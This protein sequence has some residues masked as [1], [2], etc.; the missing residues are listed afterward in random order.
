MP[1]TLPNTTLNLSTVDQLKAVYEYVVAELSLVDPPNPFTNGL[2][3]QSDQDIAKLIHEVISANLVSVGCSTLPSFSIQ[4]YDND[5]LV[6][7][8][9]DQLNYSITACNLG[10]DEGDEGDGGSTSLLLIPTGAVESADGEF[11]RFSPNATDPLGYPAYYAELDVA[12]WQES[13]I[14]VQFKWPDLTVVYDALVIFFSSGNYD[15]IE[16]SVGAETDSIYAALQ[17]ARTS[18]GE[19][20]EPYNFGV[21]DFYKFGVEPPTSEPLTLTPSAGDIATLDFT[22]TQMTL[23]VGGETQT[24]AIPVGIFTGAPL[25]NVV[26]KVESAVLPLSIKVSLTE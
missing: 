18:G 13:P 9:I 15:S 4:D 21:F 14:S 25:L 5:T 24:Y 23:T 26:A 19:Q 17:I 3:R 12:D 11:Q 22:R 20:G 16:N 10:D 6:K 7:V 1:L 2:L 8:L